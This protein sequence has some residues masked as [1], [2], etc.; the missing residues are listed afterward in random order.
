MAGANW[1]RNKQQQEKIEHKARN[2]SFIIIIII[3]ILLFNPKF[4]DDNVA[5]YVVSYGQI[6]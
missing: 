2:R 6:K 1:R 5:T 3:I 4:N